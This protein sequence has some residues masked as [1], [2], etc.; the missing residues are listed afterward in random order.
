MSAVVTPLALARVGVA[1]V[2]GVTVFGSLWAMADE[3]PTWAALVVTL[4]L[5][6]S[7]LPIVVRVLRPLAKDARD[8]RT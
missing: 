8:A 6:I 1:L 2:I 5:A 3:G 4:G 7:L